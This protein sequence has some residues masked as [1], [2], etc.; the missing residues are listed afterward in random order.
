MSLA[1]Q[2]DIFPT[3]GTTDSGTDG[4]KDHIEEGGRDFYSLARVIKFRKELGKCS[5]VVS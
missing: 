5:M 2:L 3:L 1:E 4:E